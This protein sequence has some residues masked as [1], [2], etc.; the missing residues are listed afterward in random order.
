MQGTTDPGNRSWIMFL[1]FFVS[2]VVATVP[3]L[4]QVK[5]YITISE[6]RIIMSKDCIIV[7]HFHRMVYRVRDNNETTRSDRR[8]D[9]ISPIH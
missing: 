3:M 7:N 5:T 4:I 8:K 2:S 6:N 9:D 1:R